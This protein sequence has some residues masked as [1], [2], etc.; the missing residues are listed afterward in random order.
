MEGEIDMMPLKLTPLAP[1]LIV[2]ISGATWAA[3]VPID[4]NTWSKKGPA[5][6]GNWVVAPGGATV[7]Q[8]I[9]GNP[10]FFVG[11]GSFIDTVL[12]GKITSGAGDDDLIGFVMGY[13]A[14]AGIGNDMDY[15]LLDWKQNNQASG[16][17]TSFE[18]FSL[19]R[20]NGTITDY[21]PGFWG[22]TD[23]AGFD[24]L[25]TNYS[26]TNGWA[27]GVEYSFEI[28]YR[29]DRVTVGVLGGAFGTPTTVLDVAGSFPAGQFGFYNYSQANVTY[30]GFTLEELPPTN[31]IPEPGTYALMLAG[32]VGVG[33]FARRRRNAG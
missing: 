3:E 17:F 33:L 11:P 31:P 15:V 32:L 13:N 12:R 23:S 8:T 1:I 18:G 29:A 24:N 20:V 30:S 6:N 7:N 19:N 5:A 26:T 28:A 16:G 2:F 4:L 25:A 14:P 21:I 27:A 22:R 9:N 10:T